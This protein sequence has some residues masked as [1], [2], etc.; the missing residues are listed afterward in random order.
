[1]TEVEE[2]RRAKKNAEIAGAIVGAAAAI[3]AVASARR[4]GGDWGAALGL[5]AVV[6]AAAGAVTHAAVGARSRQLAALAGARYAREQ[7]IEAD[8]VA[9]QW[10][11]L[12][13]RPGAAMAAVLSRLDTQEEGYFRRWPD[14][15]ESVGS[16]P[17]EAERI[18]QLMGKTVVVLNRINASRI[19]RESRFEIDEAAR[20][21]LEAELLRTDPDYDADIYPCLVQ[22]A[23]TE[24]SGYGFFDRAAALLDRAF[25]SGP[26]SADAYMVRARLARMSSAEEGASRSA[27][28]DLASARE[29]A[30]WA[31]PELYLE[32][33]V[34]H[35][36]LGDLGAAVA[37]LEELLRHEGILPP[38]VERE[39]IAAAIERLAQRQPVEGEQVTTQNDGPP[40]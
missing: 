6:G 34:L 5:G 23:A 39:W 11:V 28:N 7:E 29:I 21:R 20:A 10:L 36:R 22:A 2:E 32:E 27:L 13:G 19:E 14:A 24:V 17:T 25:A 1:M 15:A 16:H 3:S 35:T 26:V 4:S 12:A 37:S 30:V 40:D 9:R 31:R 38:G 18:D 33:A 8:R